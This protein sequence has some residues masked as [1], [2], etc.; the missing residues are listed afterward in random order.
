MRKLLCV[1]TALGVFMLACFVFPEFAQL[2]SRGAMPVM[3]RISG[4]SGMASF[5]LAGL[6]VLFVLALLC[7]LKKRAG[8]VILCLIV[9][10]DFLW[11]PLYFAKAQTAPRADEGGVLL[12]C[13]ELVRDL[14]ES[15]RTV[16]QPEQALALSQEVMS[17][18]AAAKA[19]RYPEW[20]RALKIAG[21]YV[22]FTGE[23]L[24]DLTRSRAAVP[25]TAAHEVAHMLGV[26]D[27]GEAN[28]LAYEKSVRYG[29]AFAYS[30]RLWALNYAL[31]RVEN[32]GEVMRALDGGILADLSS[33]PSVNG[34][35]GDY[36]AIV[37]LLIAE[38]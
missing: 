19:A 33:I 26:A 8:I 30:A 10:F 24:V 6:L 27:E 11:Y 4:L 12:L 34:V 35:D 17:A 7:L 29:G 38:M 25:F 31:D 18:P 23:A 21:V 16:I 22:P 36:G 1:L 13:S 32:P 3:S 14:N 37:D 2:I 15:G 20:M 28:L 5:P 9:A